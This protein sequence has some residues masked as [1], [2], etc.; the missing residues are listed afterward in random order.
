MHGMLGCRYS[1][2]AVPHATLLQQLQRDRQALRAHMAGGARPSV[3][4]LVPS[5]RLQE[6]LL[7]GLLEARWGLCASLT[8]RADLKMYHA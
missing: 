8:W 3:D 4:V 6:Q 5:F 1:R 7:E 2:T